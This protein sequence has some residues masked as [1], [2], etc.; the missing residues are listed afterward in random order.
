MEHITLYH[1]REWWIR[2]R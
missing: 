1:N 2:M